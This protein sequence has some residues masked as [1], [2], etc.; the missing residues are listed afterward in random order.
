[1]TISRID[2]GGTWDAFID[3][4]SSGLLFHKWDYL[5]LTAKHTESTLL[6]Y[7]IHKGD[8]LICLFPFFCRKMHGINA[9]FSPPP[10][11][12]IPH[13][14]C[15]MGANF[16]KFKQSKKESVLHLVSEDIRGALA[17]LSP[18]YIS[19]AFVPEFNDIRHYLWDRCDARI[20]YTYTIDLSQ[21][22]EEIRDNLHYKLRNK[23]KKEE[24]A[25]LRLEKTD[26]ISTLHRLLA[27]RY[28]DPS[29]DIPPIRLEYLNEIIRAYPDRIGVYH[30]YDAGGDLVGVVATQEYKRFLLWMGTPRL[31]SAHAGNEYLQW[32]LIQRAKAEGYRTFEN[33]GANNPDLAFFKSRFNPDLT[34]YFEIEKMDT[35]GAVSRWAYL[36]FA[37]RLMM[38]AGRF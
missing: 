36:T 18:N 3:A 12:I 29:L 30:L 16:E 26:D 10:L 17:D 11:T 21:P 7:A 1:M 14:G 6:P 22:L 25:G 15:I 38:A 31:E 32:L 9:V 27:D 20:R 24:K 5:H 37:K 23:L 33:M 8:E 2:D 34:T 19:I 35:L 28:R 13:L 4:S